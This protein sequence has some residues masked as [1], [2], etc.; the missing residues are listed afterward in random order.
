MALWAKQLVPTKHQ[1]MQWLPNSPQSTLCTGWWLPSRLPCDCF[2]TNLHSYFKWMVWQGV[3]VF[4]AKTTPSQQAK[5]RRNHRLS[6]LFLPQ[7]VYLSSLLKSGILKSFSG[8]FLA[9]FRRFWNIGQTIEFKHVCQ[10]DT[11][12][13]LLHKTRKTYTH[14]QYTLTL[15]LQGFGNTSCIANLKHHT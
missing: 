11:M 5:G 1:W 12:R 9:F 15:G 8:L 3:G 7:Q 4:S 14:V 6:S 10:D 13:H 2:T